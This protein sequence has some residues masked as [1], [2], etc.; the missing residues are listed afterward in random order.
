M[1]T[2]WSFALLA[3]GAAY[4]QRPTF[5]VRQNTDRLDFGR[6]AEFGPRIEGRYLSVQR[7]GTVLRTLRLDRNGGAEIVTEFRARGGDYDRRNGGPRL[8]DRDVETFGTSADQAA[9][10]RT[11]R[12]TGRWDL[13]DGKLSLRFDDPTGATRGANALVLDRRDDDFV[14]DR[15]TVVYGKQ[16]IVFHADGALGSSG[17]RRPRYGSVL[18]DGSFR[19]IDDLDLSEGRDGARLTVSAEGRRI[20]IFGRLQR[21]G[22]QA[23]LVVDQGRSRDFGTFV[24]T[25]RGS[26]VISVVGSG[27]IGGRRVSFPDRDRSPR[28]DRGWR[29]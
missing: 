16:K 29:P 15:D 25:T 4:A 13:R 26:D 5:E 20:E 19:L 21:R 22:D 14:L 6:R 18:A 2:F 8:S 9:R 12:Q 10:G 28:D 17:N 24:L 11:V 27:E 7:D 3:L 23:T 1:K